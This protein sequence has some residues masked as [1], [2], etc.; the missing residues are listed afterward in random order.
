M[1]IC[2]LVRLFCLIAIISFSGSGAE[3]RRSPPRTDH[4][5]T[6]FLRPL[7]VGAS[8]SSGM[9][10]RSPGDRAADRFGT[11][12]HVTNIARAGSYG[13]EFSNITAG[14]LLNQTSVIAIDFLFWDSTGGDIQ[15]SISSLK[16]LINAADTARIP[17]VI[18]DIPL[19]RDSQTA[20]DILNRAI[21]GLCHIQRGCYLIPL[22]RIHDVAVTRGIV[23]GGRLYHYQDLTID[24]IHLNDLGSGYISELIMSAL[25]H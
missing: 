12:D 13:R 6:A 20:R 19:L 23:I 22:S 11:S 7:I 5:A 10:A 16:N 8:V 24:G 14:S 25:R 18:G 4:A 9:L 15:A 3:A 2:L 1:K 21:H 17:L